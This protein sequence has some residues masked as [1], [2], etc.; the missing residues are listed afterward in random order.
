MNMTIE[1]LEDALRLSNQAREYSKHIK[2]INAANGLY[3]YNLNGN[4][5]F[6]DIVPY[7]L[8]EQI[9]KAVEEY[10]QDK[11]DGI[12]K[13]LKERYGVTATG[14]KAEVSNMLN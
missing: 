11:I 8:N 9:R 2:Q 6:D 13:Q 3:L 14:L 5:I 10:C 4:N 7:P 1:D 12:N